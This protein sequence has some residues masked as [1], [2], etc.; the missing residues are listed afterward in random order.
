M[1]S[2]DGRSMSKAYPPSST[3]TRTTTTS[4]A[5][6]TPNHDASLSAI[7]ASHLHHDHPQYMDGRQS[8]YTHP[9][10]TTPSAQLNGYQQ[11]EGSPAGQTSA[12]QYHQQGPLDHKPPTYSASATPS[13]DYGS[14]SSSYPEYA[15][16]GYADGQSNR[17]PGPATP[18]HA[19]AM[20]QTSSP[21]QSLSEAHRLHGRNPSN[22]TS[23][24]EV[25]IDPSIAQS[26]PSYPP[27]H[28][29]SPYPPQHDMP[30]YAG[31]PMAYG[32]PDW[33]G[34]YQQPMYGHSPVTSGAGAP[35]MVAHTLPRPPAVRAVLDPPRIPHLLILAWLSRA[36]IP[37]LRCIPSFRSL[38][39]S[40][41]NDRDDVMKRLKECTSAGGMGAKRHTAR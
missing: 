19:A 27:P 7:L 17:Y 5:A 39:R 10:L 34:Q 15:Q 6:S 18:G 13:S 3:T 2:F 28:N 4:T 26:S 8:D 11:S 29:Y 21:S 22:M 40:S 41:T 33:A 1:H 38:V 23:D 31:Q 12:V 24:G 37:S 30:Q 25:P 20:A 32:R 16:R 36:V 9:G 14:R 35:N